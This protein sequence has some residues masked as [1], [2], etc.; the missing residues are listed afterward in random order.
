M[1]DFQ[2]L[3]RTFPNFPG[4]L[5]KNLDSLHARLNIHYKAWSYKKKKHKNIKAYRKSLYKE[6]TVNRCLSILELKLFRS[7]VKGKH[8]VGR[9]FQGLAVRGKKLLKQTFLQNL[10]MV[11]IYPIYQNNDQTSHEKKEVEPIEPVLKNVHQSNTYRKDLS[12]PHFDNEPKVQEKQQVK[13]Q[14]FASLI[15][16]LFQDFSKN[17]SKYQVLP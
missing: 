3:S 17:I 15:P 7:Q 9:E 14:G 2:G 4:Y 16:G 8:F 10:G 12:W 6:P 11:T 13:D 5:K 1:H